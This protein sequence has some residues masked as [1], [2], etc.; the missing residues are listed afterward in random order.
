MTQ[1]PIRVAMIGTGSRAGYMY[2]PI[3]KALPQEVE[4]VSVWP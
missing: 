3:V 2:G 4:L 1:E